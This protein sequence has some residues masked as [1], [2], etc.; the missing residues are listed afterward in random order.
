M[1]VR[2]HHGGGESTD[3][4]ALPARRGWGPFSGQQLTVIIV[5][6]I[7]AVALPVGAWAAVTSQPVSITDATGAHVASVSNTNRLLVDSQ[8]ASPAHI[9][10]STSLTVTETS[11]CLV[12]AAPPVGRALVVRQ[13]R[14]SVY[15]NPSPGYGQNI[16]VFANSDCAA[17]GL[18]ADLNPPGLGQ[19]VV[20]F[21][22]GV[23]IPASSAMAVRVY[24]TSIW[25]DV[26]VD[27]YTVAPNQ[28]P[29]AAKITRARGGPATLNHAQQRGA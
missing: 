9:Y 10:H 28:V 17:G 14:I 21:D 19:I 4:A 3:P 8:L 7:V 2:A 24:G 16:D 15:H 13:L 6:A 5:A 29:A 22:L 18:V 25:S 12:V 1:R 23:G 20:P 27:G 26:Y 11:V